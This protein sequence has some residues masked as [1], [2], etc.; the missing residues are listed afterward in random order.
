MLCPACQMETLADDRICRACGVS[1]SVICPNCQHP[2]VLVD[3]Q[4][5]GVEIN[6]CEHCP[7]RWL[8]ADEITELASGKKLNTSSIA[9][10]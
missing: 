6:S 10:D 4:D 9:I 3:Y 2:M 5:S 7:Y 8:D 1:F